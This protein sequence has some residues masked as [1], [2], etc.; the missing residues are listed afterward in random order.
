MEES[1]AWNIHVYK[2]IAAT[3]D[4]NIRMICEFVGFLFPSP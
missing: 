3:D 1:G 2:W 4:K